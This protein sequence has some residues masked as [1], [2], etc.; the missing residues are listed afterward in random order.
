MKCC[1]CGPVRNCGPFLDKVFK[2]IE[3]I[4]SI[5][6]DY[7]ILIYYD[8]SNDNTL[9]KLKSYQK[10]NPRLKLYVNKTLVSQF[11]THRLAH[12]RNFCLNYVKSLDLNEYPFF[13]MMDFDDVNCKE[14]NPE[15]LKRYLNRDDWDALSFNTSPKYYDIWALSIYPYCF[16]YNHFNQSPKH[17]YYSIQNYIDNK[18]KH[19]RKGELLRCIS[20]FNGFS[21]Y[22]TNKFL[23]TSYNGK[24]RIDLLP[25]N[26]LLAH[27]KAA[28]STM[29][30]HDY[31]HV[32]GKYEDCEHRA[33]HIQ[34]INN[35]NAKIMISPE[36]MFY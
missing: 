15:V 24:I 20:S 26:Y 23:N 12:A 29:I 27:M 19:L 32:K 4:G 7:E 10:Q 18:L 9:D 5:F 13:I 25:K 11:R 28:D 34:A 6:D 17:D 2:N 1:I 21:I 35:D 31:G 30:F 36:I 33:F 8:K 14:V 3:K 16:S 22:R